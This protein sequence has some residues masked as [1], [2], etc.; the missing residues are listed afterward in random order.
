MM[1]IAE[2]IRAW[3]I[4]TGLDKAGMVSAA[5]ILAA[6]DADHEAALAAHRE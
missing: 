3:W 5:D 1:S 4:R 6:R 2:Q